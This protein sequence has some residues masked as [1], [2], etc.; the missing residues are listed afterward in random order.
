MPMDGIFRGAMASRRQTA[1]SKSSESASSSLESFSPV[2][3]TT[4]VGGP[5]GRRVGPGQGSRPAG[6]PKPPSAS[7]S[8]ANRDQR[9]PYCL[10]FSILEMTVWS[11]PDCASRKRWVQPSASAATLDRGPDQ[12]EAVLLLRVA[13]PAE[14]CHRPS[15]SAADLPAGYP[16]ITRRPPQ[17]AICRPLASRKWMPPGRP[18]IKHQTRAGRTRG[19]RGPGAGRTPGAE[20]E[21]RGPS[22][23][24][25]GGRPT[26]DQRLPW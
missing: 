23:A 14:P 12:V 24:P 18:E 8:R 17:P 9:M 10:P 5:G 16:A 4:R 20:R 15:L 25:G 11:M 3:S 2:R 6:A 19:R 1:S 13:R 26:A 7:T 22:G 21:H